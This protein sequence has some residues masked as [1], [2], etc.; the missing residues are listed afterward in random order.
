M[1]YFA[2]I[3]RL[4][5]YFC[6]K[7][8]KRWL[9]TNGWGKCN[10]TSLSVINDRNLTL[11]GA[12]LVKGRFEIMVIFGKNFHSSSNKKPY[13]ERCTVKNFYQGWPKAKIPIAAFRNQSGASDIILGYMYS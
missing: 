9:T 6:S 4:I 1:G 7:K 12:E 10:S 5:N 3:S 8:G 2:E 13:L 11:K